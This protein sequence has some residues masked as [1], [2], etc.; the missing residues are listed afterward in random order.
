MVCIN[1]TCYCFNFLGGGEVEVGVGRVINSWC[2][3]PCLSSCQLFDKDNIS[4]YFKAISG[5]Q[6]EEREKM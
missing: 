3:R 6:H 4:D 2:C 5:E 1:D